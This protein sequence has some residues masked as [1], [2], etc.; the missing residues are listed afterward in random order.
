MNR[1]RVALS[2][3]AVVCLLVFATPA[4]AADESLGEQ[5]EQYSRVLGALESEDEAHAA[6]TEI[7]KLRTWLLEARMLLRES[8]DKELGRMLKRAGPQIQLA[9]A[10]MEAQHAEAQ[11]EAKV[12]E[13]DSAEARLRRLKRDKELLD[14]RVA[15]L[16]RQRR[17]RQSTPSGAPA[18]TAAPPASPETGGPA[19]AQPAEPLV[20]ATPSATGDTPAGGEETE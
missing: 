8:R 17:Q 19:P 9:R 15:L 5:I 18:P 4:A 3:A 2:F 13:A 11:A 10:K 1:L 20:P 6:S 12:R 16:L 14:N 7:G